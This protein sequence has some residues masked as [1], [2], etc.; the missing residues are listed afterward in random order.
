MALR[1]MGDQGHFDP[2]IREKPSTGLFRIALALEI[3]GEKKNFD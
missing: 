1:S 2:K 3:T